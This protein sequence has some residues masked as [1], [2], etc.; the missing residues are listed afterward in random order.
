MRKVGIALQIFQQSHRGLAVF[1][2]ID[3]D[4]EN[5]GTVIFRQTGFGT[6]DNQQPFQLLRVT[7]KK[8]AYQRNGREIIRA[9]Y[10]VIIRHGPLK[11]PEAPLHGAVIDVN[12]PLVFLSDGVVKGFLPAF[13]GHGVGVGAVQGNA[14][15]TRGDQGIHQMVHGAVGVGADR[16]VAHVQLVKRLIAQ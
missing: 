6:A 3:P 10:G 1:L 11:A 15:A 2:K 13:V 9:D 4:G 5:I 14:A 8:I 7:G 16:A 12:V